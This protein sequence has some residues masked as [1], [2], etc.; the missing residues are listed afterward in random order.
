MKRFKVKEMV[1]N[2]FKN[3]VF[4]FVFGSILS[5]GGGGGYFEPNSE[6]E[7]VFTIP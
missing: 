1:Q 3:I 4:F 6:M 7:G 5:R 2:L